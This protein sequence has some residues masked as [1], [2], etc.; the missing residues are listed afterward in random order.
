MFVSGDEF[1]GVV[2]HQSPGGGSEPP[3]QSPSYQHST[4]LLCSA[5]ILES[6]FVF[7][8]VSSLFSA[9]DVFCCSNSYFSFSV[10]PAIFL[11]VSNV[12]SHRFLPFYFQISV[13]RAVKVL[14]FFS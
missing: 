2:R 11:F 4:F 3:S 8:S 14:L 13:F 1:S 7:Q 9:P 5:F 12:F 10:T 6:S